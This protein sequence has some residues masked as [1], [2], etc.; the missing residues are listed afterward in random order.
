MPSGV[1]SC[2][3]LSMT[4]YDRYKLKTAYEILTDLWNERAKE[5]KYSGTRQPCLAG[6]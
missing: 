2:V 3:C 1:K 4:K 5:K 6:V